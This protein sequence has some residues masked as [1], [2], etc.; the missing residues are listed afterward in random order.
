MP[1]SPAPFPALLLLALSS[2]LL[3]G[4]CLCDRA[5]ESSLQTPDALSNGTVEIL[6]KDGGEVVGVVA[7]DAGP[8]EVESSAGGGVPAEETSANSSS[9]STTS[10]TISST[11][12]SSTTTT[13]PSTTTSREMA[14]RRAAVAGSG[15]SAQHHH[16]A[17]PRRRAEVSAQAARGRR[18]HTEDYAARGAQHAQQTWVRPPH[19]GTQPHTMSQSLYDHFSPLDPELPS[20]DILPFLQFGM[21]LP[22]VVGNGATKS[23]SRQR[24]TTVTTS[25]PRTTTPFPGAST[26]ALVE[27]ETGNE[28]RPQDGPEDPSNGATRS[29][30]DQPHSTRQASKL[31]AAILLQMMVNN[32]RR[33]KLALGANTT[34]PR[35]EEK[36]GGVVVLKEAEI[37]S[38]E[39]DDDGEILVTGG[40]R[41]RVARPE[42]RRAN[43]AKEIKDNPEGIGA[44][45]ITPVDSQGPPSVSKTKAVSEEEKPSPGDK[46]TVVSEDVKDEEKKVG[47]GAEVAAEEAEENDD[48]GSVEETKT[49]GVEEVGK[50]AVT[51]EEVVVEDWEKGKED[52]SEEESGSEDEE[53]EDESVDKEEE[54]IE[55]ESGEDE[56]SSLLPYPK[57][58]V[59]LVSRRRKKNNEY[60][61]VPL[62]VAS[63]PSPRLIEEPVLS[64]FPLRSEMSRLKSIPPVTPQED[65]NPEDMEWKMAPPVLQTRAPE[66]VHEVK[67]N[68]TTSTTEIPIPS[69]TPSLL[70]QSTTSPKPPHV[71]PNVVLTTSARALVNDSVSTTNVPFSTS[72][73]KTTVASTTKPT[74]KQTASTTTTTTTTSSPLLSLLVN[75][76]TTIKPVPSSIH[77]PVT[78]QPY[79]PFVEHSSRQ[80]PVVQAGHPQIH[81]SLLAPV[82][83]VLSPFYKSTTTTTTTTTQKPNQ[84]KPSTTIPPS[85]VGKAPQREVPVK[86]EIDSRDWVAVPPPNTSPPPPPRIHTPKPVTPEPSPPKPHPNGVEKG[87]QRPHPNPPSQPHHFQPNIPI[88]HHFNSQWRP[89]VPQQPHANVPH[90]NPRPQ[91]TTVSSTTAGREVLSVVTSVSVESSPAIKPTPSSASFMP[92]TSPLSESVSLESGSQ[93]SHVTEGPSASD[94]PQLVNV[95]VDSPGNT[96]E[97][98]SEQDEEPEVLAEAGMGPTA[99]YVLLSLAIVPGVVAIASA[100]RC[101]LVHRKKNLYESETSSEVS[102]MG[103]RTLK[104]CSRGDHIPHTMTAEETGTTRQGSDVFRAITRLPRVAHLGW[105]HERRRRQGGGKGGRS[106]GGVLEAEEGPAREEQEGIDNPLKEALE[107]TSSWEFPRSKLRLQT[108]LGQGNFGQ[109]WKAEADGICDGEG[110]TRLVAVKLVKAKEGDDGDE[111][112]TVAEDPL[113][114]QCTLAQPSAANSSRRPGEAMTVME[115]CRRKRR[116]EFMA[117]LGIMQLL[118]PPHPNVVTLLGCCTTTEPPLLIMEYVMFGKLLTYLRDHRSKRQ[119]CNAS[120]DPEIL[121]SRDL[122]VFAYCVVKGME[123]LVSKGVVHRDLAA[124]NILVDHNKTC[125]IADF[126]MS[127]SVRETGGQIYEERQKQGALPVRWMA[128]ESL[129]RGIFTHKSDVWSFG[130]LLWEIIT[131]GST[132]YP[133]IGARDVMRRVRDGRRLERP[134]HVRPEIFRVAARCWHRDSTLRPTFSRLRADLGPLLASAA[135]GITLG[136]GTGDSEMCL[137][138]NR[139]NRRWRPPGPQIDLSRFEDD[140][141]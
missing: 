128:P 52:S 21:K 59:V 71:V 23:K 75:S 126:G 93:E 115:Q 80:P 14:R 100:A 81:P 89:S 5:K 116:E 4:T 46:A 41:D 55:N 129:F 12:I 37:R 17:E 77:P 108:L 136:S 78:R 18:R 58:R 8:E 87:W 114:Q 102:C 62:S 117:E 127:R 92:P 103:G 107:E 43:A 48:K 9:T 34:G 73:A 39:E 111:E 95:F 131:L 123:Y 141:Y 139:G 94:F 97:A 137:V 50:P 68:V 76:T 134:S 7:E 16:Q 98:D 51:E 66:I 121:T 118:S 31:K 106:G 42:G 72:T 61:A 84:E 99:T 90:S 79:R 70:A 85:T 104:S 63:S 69:T 132:P 32:V 29:R 28:M 33:K 40:V 135:T 113:A 124:R 56:D 10:T 36:P 3:A 122:L 30:N 26:N 119:Y 22:P 45:D 20:G 1:P 13:T 67:H 109:V 64:D 138:P 44:K 91:P 6:P 120:D 53:D 88:E 47:V 101:L 35:K 38:K 65:K 2:L 140:S 15:S 110:S 27:E 57:R 86:I 112:V 83:H 49:E 25:T 19:V 60:E 11:T 24:P 105:D 54:E 96:L 130:V 125:K 74:T 133:G 82:P